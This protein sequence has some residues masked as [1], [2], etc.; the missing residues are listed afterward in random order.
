MLTIAIAACA[1]IA[2]H[3]MRYARVLV[4]FREQR[5][6]RTR[7]AEAHITSAWISAV[8]PFRLGELIRIAQFI[9]VAD[10]W[11][12]G[13]AAYVMEKFLDAILLLTLAV[14]AMRTSAPALLLPLVSLFAMVVGG[15]LIA[16]AFADGLIERAARHLLFAGSSSLVTWRLRGVAQ[17]RQGLAAVRATVRQ[18]GPLL[19]LLTIGIWLLDGFAFAQTATL[20]A[21]SASVSF[22]ATLQRML[23]ATPAVAGGRY[24]QI[25]IVVLSFG[26]AGCVVS[27]GLRHIPRHRS[28]RPYRLATYALFS[29]DE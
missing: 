17:A 19:L 25:V 14:L 9:T 15:G 28:R 6:P 18:R 8:L 12:V 22:L 20:V 26:T 24:G 5:P 4:L 29:P 27:W 16:Y 2:S 1:Y 21:R 13:V 7:L 10:R 3:L 11:R 23:G